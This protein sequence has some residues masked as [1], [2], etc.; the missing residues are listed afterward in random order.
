MVAHQRL[1]RPER[2]DE[3][4]DTELL[5]GEKLEDPPTQRVGHGPERFHR[6]HIC[7]SSH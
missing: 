2:L 1:S 5:G 3:M 4:A 7:I 6:P